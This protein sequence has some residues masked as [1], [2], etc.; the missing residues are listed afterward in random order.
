[1]SVAASYTITPSDYRLNAVKRSLA[2]EILGGTLLSKRDIACIE[3]RDDE[4]WALAFDAA[5]GEHR[6]VRT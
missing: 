3:Y 2:D 6:W 4:W 1:M 5:T